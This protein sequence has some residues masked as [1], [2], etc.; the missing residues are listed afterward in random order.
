MTA[1]EVLRRAAEEGVRFVRLQFTDILGILKNVVISRRDLGRALDGVITFDGSSIDGFVRI[2]ESDMVLRADP[3]T[4]CVFPWSEPGAR[5]AR[6]I[7]DVCRTDGRSFEGCPRTALKRAIETAQQLGYALHAGPEAEFFLFLTDE[8]GRPTTQ[9]HDTGGYFDLSP[10]DKGEQAR[11]AMVLTLEEMGFQFEASHHEN[12]PGQ[13]EI[14]FAHGE[15][16]ATADN[17]VTFRHVVRRVAAR[18]GLH[19]TFMPKPIYG[20]NGCG[21]HIHL[22]LHKAGRNQFEGKPLSA[23]GLQFM[24][25]LLHHARGMCAVTNPL[26]NSY[27]RLVP[28]YEAP[29]DIAWSEQNRSPLV[30]VPAA[31]GADTRLELRSPDPSCNPYL[32]LAVILMAGLD[33]IRRK[34]PAPPPVNRNLYRLSAEERRQFGVG[35]LPRN[36]LEAVGELERDEVVR[37]ALG[38]H[39]AGRYIAAKQVEW[40]VF[41]DQ[42]HDWEVGEYLS[43]Y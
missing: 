15:A 4:W 13:H 27:K 20:I 14:R 34:L 2:E 19:A 9:T 10:V 42:V 32:A 26:V 5:T 40:D 12:S 22:S 18:H 29:V 35:S 23:I 21:M 41:H 37:S 28:G 43:R 11:R 33:G 17:L 3:A 39:I 31:A 8:R 36:L 1:D 7:C 25:G 30:R 16:L 24:A 38:E 6:L